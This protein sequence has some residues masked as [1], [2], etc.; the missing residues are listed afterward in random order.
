MNS[1]VPSH[2]TA[3]TPRHKEQR[4]ALATQYAD[5]DI[6]FWQRVIFCDEKISFLQMVWNQSASGVG[7]IQ[8]E[9]F[10]G[11]SLHIRTVTDGMTVLLR[12]MLYFFISL[13]YYYRITIKSITGYLHSTSLSYTN[14]VAR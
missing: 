8:G 2:K 12:I 6:V 1:R 5:M 4:V 3:L 13:M 10:S 14:E 9:I 7:K 11:L